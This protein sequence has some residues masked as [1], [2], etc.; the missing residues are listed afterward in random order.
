MSTSAKMQRC[1]KQ[2]NYDETKLTDIYKYDDAPKRNVFNMTIHKEMHGMH[3]SIIF[4][5]FY[6][7]FRYHDVREVYEQFP[8]DNL[9]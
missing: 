1:T 6:Y 5:I 3:T 4:K 7:I 9:T 2:T 8:F